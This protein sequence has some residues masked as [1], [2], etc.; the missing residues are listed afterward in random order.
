MDALNIIAQVK[1][2]RVLPSDVQPMIMFLTD[3]HATS[4]VL[5]NAKILEN[6]NEANK[7]DTA[8]FSLAFGRAA[9]LWTPQGPLLDQQR[10]RQEDLRGRWRLPATGRLLRRSKPTHLYFFRR[11]DFLK[12]L[13]RRA[14]SGQGQ[15][16][17][18]ER[19]N[20]LTESATFQLPVLF[21]P[22]FLLAK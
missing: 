3:G 11:R 19:F 16:Q 8:V 7:E 18:K 2:R 13:N 17:K 20:P 15:F 5:D 14:F 21:L 22:S 6:V 9:G 10:V 1:H 4:G 12:Q